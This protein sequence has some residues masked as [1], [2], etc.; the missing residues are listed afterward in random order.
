MASLSLFNR[1]LP[2]LRGIVCTAVTALALAVMTAC[3]SG[4]GGGNTPT[5][6][7]APTITSFDPS[8]ATINAGASATLTGVFANGTG[9]ITPGNLPATTGTGVTVSPAATTTYTLTVTNSA[10]AAVTQTATVTVTPVP[11]PAITDFK[12]NPSVIVAGGTSALT[13]TFT[14]GTGVITPGNIAV[15]SGTAVNVTPTATTTYTLTVTNSVGVKATKPATVTISAAPALPVISA[16]ANVTAGATGLTASVPAQDGCAYN[17]TISAGSTITNGA[18]TNAITFTA[19]S[20]GSVV[21]GCTVTN[22][23]G[24]STSAA[25]TTSTIVAMPAISDFSPAKSPITVGDSTTLT[26]TFTGG[27]G[28]VTPTVGSVTSGTAKTT[29]VL[30]VTTTYTLTVTNAA[31]TA[32][33][34]NVDVAVVAAPTITSFAAAKPTVTTGTGTTLTAIFAGG[35]ATID[36]ITGAVTSNT[37]VATGN[38]TTTTTYTLTVVNAAGTQATK[39]VTVTVVAQPAVTAFSAAA[40]NVTKGKATTLTATFTGGTGVINPGAIA[41]TS[42]VAV[43]TGNLS[44]DATY[45]LTVTN[46][47]G[48]ALVYSPTVTVHAVDAPLIQSFAPGKATVTTGSTTTLTATYTGGTGVVTAPIGA[49]TSG[50]TKTTPALSTGTTTYTL[51]VTN[52]AGDFV[53]KDA[54]ITV[55][56]APTF[57]S[58]TSD[59]NGYATNGNAAAL[60]AVFAGGTATV[61][62]ITPAPTITSGVPF[63]T[64][65]ITGTTTFHLTVTNAAGDTAVTTPVTVTKVDA[66]VINTFTAAATTVTVNHATTITATFTGGNGVL[67]PGNIAITSGTPVATGNLSSA[68]N[69]FHLAVTNLAGTTVTEVTPVTITTVPL[70]TINSFTAAQA[71]IGTGSATT[72][73]AN[74]SGGTGTVVALGALAGDGV[75]TLGT[76]N[77]NSTTTFTLSVANAAGDAVTQPLTVKVGSL[78]LLA[79]NTSGVGNTNGTLT[80]ARLN[81]PIGLMSV[82]ANLYI[83]DYN[84]GTVRMFDGTTLSTPLGQTGLPG[85]A[86]GIG[87]AAR[88]YGPAAMVPDGAGGFYLADSWNHCIRTVAVNG[89][90]GLL[91]GTPGLAGNASGALGTGSFRYPMGIVRIGTILYVADQGNHAIRA[92]DVTNGS[93]TTIAGVPGT[94][95]AGFGDGLATSAQFNEPTSIVAIGTTLYVTDQKNHRIRSIDTSN[96]GGPSAV[97]TLTGTVAS[98]TSNADLATSTFGSPFGLVTDGTVLY[99]SD[100]ENSQVRKVDIGGN[101]VTLVAGLAGGNSGSN[102]AIGSSA[103]FTYPGGLALSGNTLYVADYGN[104]EVRTI[105][106]TVGGTYGTVA[107]LVGVPG[108]TGRHDGTGSVALFNTPSGMVM[109]ATYVYVSDSTNGTVV[110]VNHAGLAEALVAQN[111]FSQN[112][113]VALSPDGL[114]LYV[115]DGG[116]NKIQ[117]IDLT[118]GNVGDPT[119]PTYMTYTTVAGSGTAGFLDVPTASGL[120]TTAQ[121]SAPTGVATDSAG[122]IY[123][124]DQ[125]NNRIRLINAAGVS[126]LAGDGTQNDVNDPLGA[127]ASFDGPRSLVVNAAGTTLYVT[128]QGNNMVRSISLTAPYAVNLVAGAIAAGSVDATGAAARFNGPA[129]ISIDAAGNLYV[130]DLYNNT[131]RMISPAGVVSTLAGL[132]GSMINITGASAVPLPG[133]LAQ[134]LGVLVDST[135]AHVYIAVPDALLHVAF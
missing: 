93:I 51:T 5:P 18:T 50:A 22:A 132:S 99:V 47:A 96:L 69:V 46:A 12:A 66:P 75:A 135:L 17:W 38:L 23:A 120:P 41:V 58:F 123:V 86:G 11:D 92:V 44:A 133:T 106:L 108:K 121:F 48:T 31:G 107:T 91:A 20:T 19:G 16:P 79:G 13:G 21:L 24:L 76:G 113:S 62:N 87:N 57:T 28:V 112:H 45:T 78:A 8:P 1:R 64:N 83:S 80:Q 26:G 128:D 129:G 65:A 61:D 42:G 131:I 53:T 82:G 118:S 15:T 117:K 100:Y 35:T 114:S 98:G 32:V 74:Y 30:N 2:D 14:G 119:T 27:T 33:T 71:I 89:T 134:P 122:N 73:S 104:N 94:G 126:T 88:F 102:D 6:P 55:V 103:S 111:T 84:A 4:G 63:S 56:V 105:D 90:V 77:L 101:A 110:R 130:A 10:G 52:A 7:A 97:G 127:N 70:A 29:G 60:T 36:K 109:D 43:S 81:S 95:T 25:A 67:T 40:A 59:H 9:V 54:V 49:I 39:P 115:A 68:T 125:G 124:A 37:G 85:Y 34:K 3:G 72:L 116:H